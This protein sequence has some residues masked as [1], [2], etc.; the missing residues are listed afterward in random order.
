ME[1]IGPDN[2]LFAI[3]GWQTYVEI[4]ISFLDFQELLI[5]QILEIHFY[6]S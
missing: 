1:T 4:K 5:R 3:D 2:S 6:L